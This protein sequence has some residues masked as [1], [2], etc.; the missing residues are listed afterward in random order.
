M[1]FF[2][3]QLREVQ[4][5]IDSLNE[6]ITRSTESVKSK[7]EQLKGKNDRLREIVYEIQATSVE[8]QKLE[9]FRR[10]KEEN[11]ARISE[12]RVIRISQLSLSISIFLH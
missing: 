2:E 5:E 8:S 1:S 11:E 3:F 7:R 4:N 12:L 9:H 10:E 6:K